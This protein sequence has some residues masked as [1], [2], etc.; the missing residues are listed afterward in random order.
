MVTDR[1][2]LGPVEVRE[3]A[4]RLDLTPTKRH[5]QNFV[6]DPNT[7]RK[8]VRLADVTATDTVLEIGPG[9]GSLTLGLLEAGATVQAIE[10]DERLAALLPETVRQRMPERADDLQ[11]IAGDA[12]QVA[13][14]AGELAPTTMVANL[15]YNVAVPVVLRMFAELSTL[16]RGLV[17]V[18]LE[19]AQRLAATP[20]SRIYGVPSVKMAWFGAVD[21]AGTVGPNVFWPAPRIDSGLVRITCHT[22][23]DSR[24]GRVG[25]FSAID[26]GF[27][28]R[29]K[30]LR[31]ALATWA[32]G[33]AKADEILA[34]AGV[35]ASARGEDLTL[36]SFVRIADARFDLSHA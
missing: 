22:P 4:A 7:V 35:D 16:E 9:I 2:L 33:V 21:F 3:I 14:G 26:A 30:K 20:G 17:M 1:G 13:L 19:V 6:I 10:I 36:A 25:V 5:G 12:M 29:R 18:Q 31:S 11:V 28:Q 34:L 24:A 23:P 15:P 8:I 27:S 32:G